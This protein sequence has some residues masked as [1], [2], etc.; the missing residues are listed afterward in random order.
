MDVSLPFDNPEDQDDSEYIL[1]NAIGITARINKM[2]MRRGN[3]ATGGR[4]Y[5]LLYESGV[6]YTKPD[7]SDGRR[8][9]SKREKQRL[10]DFL[11][12]AGQEPETA[13]MCLRVIQGIE[14]FL[15]IP[16]LYQRGKGDCNELVPVR[17]AELWSAGIAASPYLTRQTRAGGSGGF[18]Y[19]AM[20]K[21]EDGSSEDPSAILGMHGPDGADLRNEEIR[22]N[23]ERWENHIKE[24]QRLAAADA[25][26]APHAAKQIDQMGFVPRGGVFRSPYD[27]VAP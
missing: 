7:Q 27:R 5:P 21:Y 12:D 11:K 10:I 13:L 25:S 15:G 9:L 16:E 20:I 1:L 24:A 6:V 23:V 26:L 2:H 17:L 8:Q 18:V 3:P 4:P 14:I 19:H 22:K